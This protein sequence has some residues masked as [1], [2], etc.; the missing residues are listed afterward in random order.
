MLMSQA[1]E[2]GVD[3]KHRDNCR[4]CGARDFEL[5]LPIRPSAIGDAFLP[6]EQAERERQQLYP[7]NVYLCLACGHLQNLDVVDPEI[8][9]RNYTYRTSVSVGLVEHFRRYAAAVVDGLAIAP[10]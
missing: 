6:R 3:F 8:L 1:A 4:L 5:V 2:S 9:F 10:G 7:L